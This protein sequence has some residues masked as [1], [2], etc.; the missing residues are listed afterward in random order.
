MSLV[1]VRLKY[2][3]FYIRTSS[4]RKK[5][6]VEDRLEEKIATGSNNGLNFSKKE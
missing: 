1:L 5:L 3:W 2:G 6:H 4:G